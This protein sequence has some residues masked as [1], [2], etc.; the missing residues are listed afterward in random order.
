MTGSHSIA[1]T[2][3]L[4]PQPRTILAHLLKGNDISGN[5]SMITFGIYRLSDCIMKIRNAG[6]DIVTDMRTDPVGRRYARYSL[7]GVRH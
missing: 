1:T 6:Y 5:E 2:L 4:A 3:K 7:A